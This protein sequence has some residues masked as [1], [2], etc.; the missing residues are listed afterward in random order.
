MDNIST[1]N[2]Q[3][4]KIIPVPDDLIG[5]LFKILRYVNYLR[6]IKTVMFEL[7]TL[8]WWNQLCF[9]FIYVTVVELFFLIYTFFHVIKFSSWK[10]KNPFH[11][12]FI[13]A[14]RKK[15]MWSKCKI[16]TTEAYLLLWGKHIVKKVSVICQH[17]SEK[18]FE[19]N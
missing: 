11:L 14:K 5:K 6:K 4:Y 9:Y 15:K 17:F 10:T 8:L 3:Y 19:A 1:V 13:E 12:Y 2:Y 18:Y 16:Y 7:F